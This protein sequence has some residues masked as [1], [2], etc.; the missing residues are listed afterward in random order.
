[1]SI[2][3]SLISRLSIHCILLPCLNNVHHVRLRLQ[4]LCLIAVPFVVERNIATTMTAP[5]SLRAVVTRKPIIVR[6][7]GVY[8]SSC[9]QTS[10]RTQYGVTAL[11]NR[12]ETQYFKRLSNLPLVEH[13]TTLKLIQTR[14]AYAASFST[15]STDPPQ[16][17]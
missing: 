16:T 9:R 13:S 10:N 7:M 8:H 2:R 1:M 14:E 3:L 11:S 17:S 5:L 4:Y 12:N 6:S 15:S